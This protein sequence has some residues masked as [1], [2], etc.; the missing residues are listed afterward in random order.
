[1]VSFWQVWAFKKSKAKKFMICF[2]FFEAVAVLDCS[3]ERNS[4]A[5]WFN[6]LCSFWFWSALFNCYFLVPPL[7]LKS[8]M[9]LCF[10]MC[11]CLSFSNS[12][13]NIMFIVFDRR[14]LSNA[15]DFILDF[16]CLYHCGSGKSRPCTNQSPI[17]VLFLAFGEFSINKVS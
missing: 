14:I 12:R 17:F 6:E 7:L 11:K 13:L 15:F 16:S 9:K 1:M 3:P 5:F 8:L 10:T 4:V 2:E